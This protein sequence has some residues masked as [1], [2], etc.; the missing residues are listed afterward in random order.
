MQFNGVNNKERSV[1]MW[2]AGICL[3]QRIGFVS[4]CYHHRRNLPAILP[5]WSVA[6]LVL[7]PI[8]PPS[9][10]PLTHQCDRCLASLA[11]GLMEAHDWVA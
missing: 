6:A 11:W 8:L 5:S 9:I 10:F 1:I 4:T 2:S 7:I 3:V